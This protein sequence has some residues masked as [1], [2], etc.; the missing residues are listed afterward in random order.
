MKKLLFSL[1][2][3]VSAGSVSS[4]QDKDKLPAPEVKSVPLIF[5]QVSSDP[6]KNHFN[7]QRSRAAESANPQRP[8]FEFTFDLGDQRDVQIRTVEVYKSYRRGATGLIGPRVL[9][10]E[11]TSF[12]AT[13]TINSQEA[14]TGLQRMQGQDA[15]L[16]PLLFPVKAAS[17]TAPNSQIVIN[18]QIIFT[19]EYVLQDGSRVVLTPLNKVRVASPST[20]EVEVVSG[21]QISPPFA[22]IATFRN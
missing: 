7:W 9:A 10:R 6:A 21:T 4:C 11:V 14:I 16:L 2:L 12:P 17:P 8:V 3:L 18:D 5:P 22:V 19:F 15:P 20:P 13:I 1:L